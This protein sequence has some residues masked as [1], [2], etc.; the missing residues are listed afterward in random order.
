MA[1]TEDISA[2]Y[3]Y[4][5]GPDRIRKPMSPELQQILDDAKLAGFTVSQ[6]DDGHWNGDGSIVVV[7]YRDGELP[8]GLMIGPDH[9]AHRLDD[10]P[11]LAEDITDYAV[12]RS[13]LELQPQP[14]TQPESP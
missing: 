6:D 2:G 7:K 9:I 10:K 3:T 8:K 12:M 1:D 5:E 14:A 11:W 13:V 4:E